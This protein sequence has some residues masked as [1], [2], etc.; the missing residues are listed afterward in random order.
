[1]TE[2]TSSTLGCGV[3][4]SDAHIKEQF[5]RF[6]IAL[7]THEAVAIAAPPLATFLEL[8]ERAFGRGVLEY[9][10]E[11]ALVIAGFQPLR[12]DAPLTIVV[13]NAGNVRLI[14]VRDAPEDD[15]DIAV[16]FGTSRH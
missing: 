4:L 16:P 7:D 1:M 14:A 5:A 15:P 10:G 13:L 9:Q 11:D 8:R 3:T 2:Q 6:G 12:E